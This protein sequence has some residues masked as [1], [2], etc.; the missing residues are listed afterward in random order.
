ML[1][2][3]WWCFLDFA[4]W[5]HTAE[6]AG[7]AVVSRGGCSF[8]LRCGFLHPQSYI[9]LG[10]L[11]LSKAGC[12]VAKREEMGMGRDM[13]VERTKVPLWS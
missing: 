10:C 1:A 3:T 5:C 4:A 8:T 7:A 13:R 11:P 12:R 2:G 6:A 9:V